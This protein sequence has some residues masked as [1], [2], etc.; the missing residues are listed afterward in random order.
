VDGL[1]GDSLAGAAALR[2]D[3]ADPRRWRWQR[4]ASVVQFFICMHD[5]FILGSCF[6]RHGQLIKIVL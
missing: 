5:S 1:D 4:E 3:D 6:D 2:H